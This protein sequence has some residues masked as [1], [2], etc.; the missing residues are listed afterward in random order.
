MTCWRSLEGCIR[1]VF[2]IMWKPWMP[3]IWTGS[4][5]SC[6]FYRAFE[7]FEQWKDAMAYTMLHFPSERISLKFWSPSQKEDGVYAMNM[8]IGDRKNTI[9]LIRQ[10]L[11]LDT[12]GRPLSFLQSGLLLELPLKNQF[13]AYWWSWAER[14]FHFMDIPCSFSI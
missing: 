9:T 2:V 3:W 4:M 8:F 1:A 5:Q 13:Q 10:M 11:L 14:T 12:S 7:S 6:L